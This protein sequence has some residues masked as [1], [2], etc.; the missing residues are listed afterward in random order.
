MIYLEMIKN[1]GKWRDIASTKILC[2]DQVDSI[3]PL[4][5]VGLRFVLN[6]Q[7]PGNSLK[8][9]HYL[10]MGHTSI[11]G[12]F[13]TLYIKFTHILIQY[14]VSLICIYVTIGGQN[15]DYRRNKRSN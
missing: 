12:R 3:F 13:R 11:V 6:F 1:L 8:I 2:T 15:N 7:I 5:M 4:K 9:K 10:N 14:L